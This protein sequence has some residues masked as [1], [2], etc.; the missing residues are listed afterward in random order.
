MQT[1]QHRKHSSSIV[2]E[3]CYSTQLPSKKSRRESH[4]KHQSFLWRIVIAVSDI[5]AYCC[6]HY[7]ATVVYQQSFSAGTFLWS[8]CLAVG[9]YVTI[10][11]VLTDEIH[12][13]DVR[14][15]SFVRDLLGNLRS[16]GVLV[17]NSS[18]L[19]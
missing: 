4:R 12:Y 16:R 17:L 10:L 7:P 3:A 8:R 14:N 18:L 15:S 19:W 2:V 5:V 9:R 1:K 13:A 6:T 11:L